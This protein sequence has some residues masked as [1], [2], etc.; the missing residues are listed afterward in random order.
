M[1]FTLGEFEITILSDF[2][3]SSNENNRSLFVMA[4]IDGK[5]TL[6]TGDAEASCEKKLLDQ[7]LD[8]DC[9]VLKVGHP[10]SNTSSSNNFLKETTPDFGVIS[11]GEDNMYYHPHAKTLSALKNIGTKI[12][13]T[14]YDG[15]VIFNFENGKIKTV[16]E[17]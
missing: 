10:G 11:V 13:R 5:K 12:F 2:E 9:D 8:I 16:T 4:E 15:D 1:N 17:K 6:F 14:D 3:S 7:N